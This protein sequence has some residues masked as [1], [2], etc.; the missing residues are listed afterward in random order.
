[1]FSSGITFGLASQ[2]NTCGSMSIFDLTASSHL[3]TLPVWQRMRPRIPFN[4]LYAPYS[5]LLNLYSPL[6]IASNNSTCSCLYGLGLPLGSCLYIS[7]PWASQ[8]TAC[9]LAE[10]YTLPLVAWKVSSTLL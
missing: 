6:A 4:V 9:P 10:R 7:L 3:I 8:R 2:T 5:A 1:P